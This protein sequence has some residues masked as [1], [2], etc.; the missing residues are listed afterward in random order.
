MEVK[1]NVRDIISKC[2]LGI[3]VDF[4]N[5]VITAFLKV[6]FCTFEFVELAVRLVGVIKLDSLES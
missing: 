3:F 4:D 2:N 1:F 5:K 6:Y